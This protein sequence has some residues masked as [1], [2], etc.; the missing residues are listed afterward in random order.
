[1]E[2]LL[3]F[4][5]GGG[6]VVEGLEQSEFGR[7]KVDSARLDLVHVRDVPF[8]LIIGVVGTLSLSTSRCQRPMGL[9]FEVDRPTLGERRV[10]SNFVKFPPFS[11]SFSFSITF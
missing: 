3:R 8:S 5:G 6:Q 4:L 7:C 9:L 11:V 10:S 2:N 1:M